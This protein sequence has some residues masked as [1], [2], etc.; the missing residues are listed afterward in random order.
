MI[1]IVLQ[2]TVTNRAQR[3]FEKNDKR[4]NSFRKYLFNNNIYYPT[5]GIIFLATTNSYQNLKHLIN[6]IQKGFR[7][8][9][10]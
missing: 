7:K 4:I 6:S 1:R 2:K 3:D 8:F 10:K 9:F 5:S